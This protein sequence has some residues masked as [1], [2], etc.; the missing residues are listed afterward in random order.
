MRLIEGHRLKC[1]CSCPTA[2]CHARRARR[3]RGS[4]GAARLVV[5]NNT[6]MNM[7]Y[8]RAHFAPRSLSG[9]PAA[10]QPL[11]A[12]ASLLLHQCRIRS[13]KGLKRRL[14][15]SMRWPLTDR[16]RQG[17][18]NAANYR[19]SHRKR[20]RVV[21]VRMGAFPTKRPGHGMCEILLIQSA[22]RLAVT[23]PDG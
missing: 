22:N 4:A 18:R 6:L 16:L 1:I 10:E 23:L 13:A 8:P 7:E 11:G 20:V 19:L 17:I 15:G 9:T 14:H 2:A 5:R 3:W 21:V 12:G